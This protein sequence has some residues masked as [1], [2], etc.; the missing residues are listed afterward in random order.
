MECSAKLVPQVN[1]APTSSQAFGHPHADRLYNLLKRTELPEIDED[2]RKTLQN[3]KKLCKAC[4]TH[5]QAPRRFKFSL[6]D[7]KD[8]NSFVFVEI[9]YVNK[10]IVLQVLDEVQGTELRDGYLQSSLSPCGKKSV[11]AA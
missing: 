5:A 11:F 1:R 10:Q 8:F 3:L 9:F 2:T 7:V 6:R 4:Q